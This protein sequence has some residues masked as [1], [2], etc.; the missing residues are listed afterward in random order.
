VNVKRER[1]EMGEGR[2]R[3]GE[4]G[5]EREKTIRGNSSSHSLLSPT[6]QLLLART[7]PF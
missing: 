4:G 5:R 2:E 7:L 6:S 1:R 3:E